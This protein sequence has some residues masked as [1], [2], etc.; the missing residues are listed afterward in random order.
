MCIHAYA[1]FTRIDY[2]RGGGEYGDS[3]HLSVKDNK[4]VMDRQVSHDA[5]EEHKEC[6]LSE[7]AVASLKQV[8][9]KYRMHRWK[10]PRKE[11]YSACDAPVVTFEIEFADHTTICIGSDEEP[12]KGGGIGIRRVVEILENVLV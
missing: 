10:K 4:L 2:Y 5:P 7:E 3:Y 11:E 6:N 9:S 1:K 8:I 12:P